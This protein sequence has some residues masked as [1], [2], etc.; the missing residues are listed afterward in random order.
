MENELEQANT[1]VE[2]TEQVEEEAEV[3]ANEESTSEKNS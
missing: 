3:I 2:E 1:P